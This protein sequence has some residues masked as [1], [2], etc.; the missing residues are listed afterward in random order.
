MNYWYVWPIGVVLWIA[1]GWV[2]FG[3]VEASALKAKAGSNKITLS[4]FIYTVSTKFPLAMAL[5]CMFVGLFFGILFTHFYWHWCPP[6][7]I[8]EG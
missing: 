6:G 3:V 5:G 1:L 7:S 8:S 2:E 4:M